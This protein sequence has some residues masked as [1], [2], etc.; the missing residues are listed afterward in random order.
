[1]VK[2]FRCFIPLIAIAVFF[3]LQ[4]PIRADMHSKEEVNGLIV[5]IEKKIDEIKN[6]GANTYAGAEITRILDHIE[7]TK[8]LLDKGYTDKAYFEIRIG[9]EYI[10]LIIAR[11]RLL[12]SKEAHDKFDTTHLK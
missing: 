10:N 4:D 7:S 3:F 11:E 6:S 5:K 1:M 12:K 2:Y 9:V 8:E